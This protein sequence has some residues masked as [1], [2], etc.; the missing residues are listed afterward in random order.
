MIKHKQ[1]FRTVMAFYLNEYCNINEGEGNIGSMNT[2]PFFF[3]FFL[4]QMETTNITER[5]LL[6]NTER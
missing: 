3:V 6:L 4:L 1:A 5:S 2:Y